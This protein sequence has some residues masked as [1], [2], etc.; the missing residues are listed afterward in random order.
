MLKYSIA[1]F[2]DLAPKQEMESLTQLVYA[3]NEMDW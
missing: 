1:R 3:M 2:L